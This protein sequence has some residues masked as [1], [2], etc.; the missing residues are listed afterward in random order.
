MQFICKGKIIIL[1]VS[2][3]M[4]LGFTGCGRTIEE[5]ESEAVEKIKIGIC[6]DSFLVERWERDRDVFVTTANDLGAEVDVQN[7][8]GDSEAQVEAIE[9]FIKKNMDVIVIV[10]IDSDAIAG[11]VEKARDK[12]IKVISYDR[13]ITDSE[14]DLYISFD[15]EAVG[16]CMGNGVGKKLKAGDKVL[17]IC[18]PQ[19]DS[20]VAE[21]AKGFSEKAAENNLDIIDTVYLDAWRS[22]LA[23]EYVNDNIDLV[24]TDIKAIM[25]GNDNLAAGVINALAENRL[26]GDIVVVGQDAELSACQRIVEGTQ[27]ATVYKPVNLLASQAAHTAVDM[28]MGKE[29]VYDREIVSGKYRVPYIRLEP[30]LVTA[31]NMESTIISDGFHL[32][33]EIYINMR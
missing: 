22:E 15:N 25:C 1:L 33:S 17:M 7:P 27:L 26:A 29:L 11:V 10:P 28:A 23:Y 24:R 8:N 4:L 18:G 13:M 32:E 14:V 12:G 31:E 6:F 3:V 19:T 2:M 16:Q 5:T 20:N 30:T 9:Y 21:V